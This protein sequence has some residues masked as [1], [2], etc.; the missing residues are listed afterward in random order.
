MA[1]NLDRRLCRVGHPF[2]TYRLSNDRDE[3]SPFYFFSIITKVQYLTKSLRSFV[4]RSFRGNNL[5]MKHL[6]QCYNCSFFAGH[7]IGHTD[8]ENLN[9]HEHH[10]VTLTVM[11]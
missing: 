1:P 6:F 3:K 5:G 10:G 7:V 8:L 9:Q 2:K 11:L 4:N